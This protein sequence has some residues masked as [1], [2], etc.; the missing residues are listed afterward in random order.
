MKFAIE[1][2]L[3]SASTDN[4]D[5]AFDI[6]N[7]LKNVKTVTTDEHIADV[8]KTISA[9]IPND[10]YLTIT[11]DDITIGGESTTEYNGNKIWNRD[12]CMEYV[13]DT[14]ELFTK[15]HGAALLELQVV[16][17]N[18]IVGNPIPDANGKNVWLRCVFDVNGERRIT[19]WIYY[20]T[21]GSVA[22][23]GSSCAN[24]CGYNVR[25]STSFRGSV[26]GSVG[27]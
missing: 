26:F 19:P 13:K 17:A 14:S 20:T 6:L 1:H 25:G 22:D 7:L 16:Q 21:Y 5:I 3:L 8:S 27:N 12:E 4:I 10:K 24:F 18:N 9:D 11:A 23:C 2:E 15:E